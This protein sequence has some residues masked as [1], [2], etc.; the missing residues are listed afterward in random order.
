MKN[1]EFIKLVH[2]D[3]IKCNEYITDEKVKR[4][5]NFAQIMEYVKLNSR[6]DEKISE[7]QNL[8]H[9]RLSFQVKMW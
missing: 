2:K 4:C 6:Q 9:K 3:F 1:N 5:Y 8:H 7:I